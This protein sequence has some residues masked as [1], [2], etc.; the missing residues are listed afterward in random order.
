MYGTTEKTGSPACLKRGAAQA[1]WQSIPK[2]LADEPRSRRLSASSGKREP[3]NLKNLR[4]Q[5]EYQF[6]KITGPR[7]PADSPPIK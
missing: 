5:F 1:V 7:N 2:P 3:A 4:T 6:I